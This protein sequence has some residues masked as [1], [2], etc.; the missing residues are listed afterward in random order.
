MLCM[1]VFDRTFLF[2]SMNTIASLIRYAPDDAERAVEDLATLFRASLSQNDHLV[3]WQQELGICLAYLRI[4]QQ[5]LGE[6]LQVDW[7]LMDVPECCRLPPLSLQPLIENAI[8]H[9][10]ESLSAGGTIVIR[11]NINDDVLRIDVENPY[12][13]RGLTSFGSTAKTH[14]GVALDNIRARLAAIYHT[15]DDRNAHYKTTISKE[16]ISK[17]PSLKSAEQP[18]LAELVLNKTEESF[19]ATLMLPINLPARASTVDGEH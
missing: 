14:N 1:R 12:E 10:I 16:T 8:Y 13:T 6:R 19:T 4:E 3:S 11:V 17:K 9:G 2:N 18:P 5:R 15:A 7:Q